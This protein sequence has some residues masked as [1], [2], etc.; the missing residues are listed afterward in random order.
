VAE[1][2]GVEDLLGLLEGEPAVT[3]V[4]FEAGTA[5][6]DLVIGLAVCGDDAKVRGETDRAIVVLMLHEMEMR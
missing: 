6:D 2:A 4:G 1:L 3:A 5:A